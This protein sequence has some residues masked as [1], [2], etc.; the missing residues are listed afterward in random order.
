MSTR[1]VFPDDTRPDFEVCRDAACDFLR[2]LAG[3]NERAWFTARREIYESEIRFPLECL[4]AEFRP[5]GAGKGLPVRGDPARAI[6]RIHR[7]VRFSKNKQPYKTHAGAILSRSGGRD[8]AGVVYLH[9]Q[10]GNC[11]VSAGFWRVDPPMLNAWR[12]RMIDMPE[13][14]LAIVGPYA[15]APGDAPYM[16]AI[17]TLKTMPRGYRDQAGT[18]AADYLKWKSFLLTRQVPDAVVKTRDFVGVIREHALASVPLLEYGWEVAEIPAEADPRRHMR[19][20]TRAACRS[21]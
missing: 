12:Q 7:D 17:S 13:E 3:N 9:V 19:S 10:P 14:W 21:E 18:K 8:E 11:F 6:F 20:Q 15:A 2:G 16:R 4:V 5:D 1:L